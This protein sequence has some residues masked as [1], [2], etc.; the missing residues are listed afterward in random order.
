MILAAHN[1][2]PLGYQL[3]VM[4]LIVVVA[5]VAGLNQG[6]NRWRRSPDLE[7]LAARLQ[8]DSFNPEP[9][10]DFANG[11]GFLSRLDKGSNRYAFNILQGKYH[12]SALFVFDYHYQ[13][14]DGK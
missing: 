9:N 7:A 4:A 14:D 10:K 11:W 3:L 2:L 8:F 5:I 12:E 6:R 13:T 1:S